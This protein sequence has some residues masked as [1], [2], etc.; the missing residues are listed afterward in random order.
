MAIRSLIL[1]FLIL[2]SAAS[3]NAETLDAKNF[4]MY[5]QRLAE[6]PQVTRILEQGTRFKELSDGE[7]GLPDP[8]IILGV[9]NLP[10]ND[11]AFDQ[12][13]PSSKVIGF[14]QQI[15]SYSLRKAKSERQEQLSAKQQLIADYTMQ[16]LKAML[17]S[18]LAKLDKVKQQEAYAKTQ[19]EHYKS[20][21]EYFKGRLESGSGVYWRF[22]E[23]DVERSLVESKLNDLKAERDDIEAELVRLVGEVPAI[24]LPSIPQ[25]TWDSTGETVYPVLIARED[26]DI[27]DKDVDAADA[28]FN[29]NYGVQAIYKQR[30]SGANFRGDDWFSVQ[31]SISIPLW[32]EWNQ[33]PKLRAA[34]ASKR[35]AENAYDDTGRMWRRKLD[36]LASKRD[37]TLDN[38]MVFVEKDKALDEMVAAA[39]R[40]YEAGETNLD[41]VLDAQIN[42]LTIKSQ[43]AEKRAQH[44]MLAAEF[45]SHIIGDK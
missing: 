24:P 6:H 3:A 7:M 21:E 15:P 8:S 4:D 37:A 30:E 43:L 20:L 32:Y 5:V 2:F 40:T 36:A 1:T 45:N 10:V 39:E 38:V 17:T 28:S 29:P 35:S 13:L 19:L 44:L 11:P 31:A 18:M 23:V 33:K 34:E 26:I 25:I 9:D 22:S 42:Q 27:A 14:K 16:R 41:A 12:F